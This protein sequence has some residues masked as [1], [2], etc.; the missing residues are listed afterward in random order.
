MRF[1]F[2]RSKNRIV[3]Q[4]RGISLME[5]RRIFD[6]AYLLD[7]RTDNPEQ[8][9]AIGW[10][11]GRLCSVVFEIRRDPEGEYYHLITAWKANREE[12]QAYAENV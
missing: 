9:R 12:Q 11:R 1:K 4:K 7:Q 8:F 6:Q 3:K 5:A 10:C 2:D